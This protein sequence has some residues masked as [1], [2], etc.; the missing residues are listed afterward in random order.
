MM[1]V[2]ERHPV[3]VASDPTAAFVHALLDCVVV[4]AAQRLQ[5]A[6]VP[7]LRIVRP[8][9]LDDMVNCVRRCNLALFLAHTAQ[10]VS[11]EE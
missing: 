5:V 6:L 10:R 7:A 1:P 11:G 3:R 4:S 8:V 2:V 9:V